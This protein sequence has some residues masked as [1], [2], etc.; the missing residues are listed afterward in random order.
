MLNLVE[1]EGTVKIIK[2]EPYMTTST[3]YQGVEPIYIFGCTSCDKLGTFVDGWGYCQIVLKKWMH[4]S[5]AMKDLEE[6]MR[7]PPP[8]P[9]LPKRKVDPKGEILKKGD[10]TKYKS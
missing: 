5:P 3:L 9:R 4:V 1:A 6:Q 7:G 2:E 8:V 10:P